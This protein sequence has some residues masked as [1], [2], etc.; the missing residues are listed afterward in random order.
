M[1]SLTPIHV[2]SKIP[3]QQTSNKIPQNRRKKE[4][5]VIRGRGWE[6]HKLE[7]SSQKLKTSSYNINK[8]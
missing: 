7:E 3:A 5:G 4:L 8:Y 1:I 2:Q 6:R